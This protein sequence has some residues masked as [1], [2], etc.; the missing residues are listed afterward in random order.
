AFLPELLQRELQTPIHLA[1]SYDEEI[2]CVGVRRLLDILKEMPIRPK[3]CIIGEPTGMKVT[4]GHKGKK[5]VRCHVRGLEAHSSLAPRAVN[6]VEMAAEVIV[7]LRGMAGRFA[8]EG[9]FDNEYDGPH[10]MVNT[11]VVHGGRALN[12]VPKDCHFDFDFRFLPGQNVTAM[13]EEV[14]RFAEETLQPAMRRI[15]PYAGFTWEDLSS[16]PGLA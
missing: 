1:F 6:A 10:T 7:Y 4:V 2:G 13:F 12:I 8:A 5:S 14:R 3:A 11:G 9:P 16:F 15:A